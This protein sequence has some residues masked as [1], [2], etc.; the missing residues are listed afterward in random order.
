[1]RKQSLAQKHR[2]G[3]APCGPIGYLLTSQTEE[4]SP[5]VSSDA[6]YKQPLK[7]LKFTWHITQ[8]TGDIDKA[9]RDGARKTSCQSHTLPG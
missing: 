8:T 9:M 4:A 1:M 5:G 3:P 6:F 7:V 2:Q